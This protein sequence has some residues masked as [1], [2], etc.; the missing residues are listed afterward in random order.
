M[1]TRERNVTLTALYFQSDD[2][3]ELTFSPT[4]PLPT[5]DRIRGFRLRLEADWVDPWSGVNQFYGVFS[6]GIHGLGSI[7]NN[8]PFS[9]RFAGR[10]DFN[11]VEATYARVQALGAGYSFFVAALGQY[12][13]T[14]LLFP[15]VCGY[16]GRVFGRAYDPSQLIGD[17]CAEILGELRYD[18][19][20]PS[21]LLS[22][23]QFYLYADQAWLRTMAPF[24]GGVAGRRIRGAL[25]DGPDDHRQ[26]QRSVGRGWTSAWLAQCRHCGPLRRQG[27][28]RAAGRLAVPIHRD[29]PIL[30][31]RA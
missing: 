21:P 5:F 20:P 26:R 23:V 15:E 22:Q 13:G 14:P 17:H 1:R 30:R 25:W 18:M 9:S 6:Q 12:A 10:V 8:D 27:D 7:N 29:Q 28:R 3:S 2:Q 24:T 4:S 19:R 11:K 16:G 31:R